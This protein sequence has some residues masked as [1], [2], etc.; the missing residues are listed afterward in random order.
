M[1]P[2]QVLC[3]VIGVAYLV[4][5]APLVL[6]PAVTRRLCDRFPRDRYAGA[7]LA[8]I[9]LAWS[10]WEVNDMPLG[11]VD[12]YK[13]SLWVVT[14]VVYV[15]VLAFM[16]ELLAVRALGGLLLLCASPVLDVQRMHPSYW[17][18]VIAALAYLWVVAGVI[19]VLSPYRFRHAVERFCVTDVLCRILGA[20][21]MGVGVLLLVL[22]FTVFKV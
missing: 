10:A 4:L 15:L 20:A 19:F 7:V 6:A 13:S 3:V 1:I 14:P 12:A 18:W 8:A 17:T 21:G 5:H 16:N 11:F 22:G 9:A 2:L